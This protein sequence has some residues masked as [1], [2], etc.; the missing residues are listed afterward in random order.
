MAATITTT[1]LIELYGLIIATFVAI[2]IN[3]YNSTWLLLSVI[4]KVVLQLFEEHATNVKRE[5]PIP[6]LDSSL[7]H[8]LHTCRH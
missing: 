1:Q 8:R 6:R 5:T 4:S 3:P 2:I 7:L